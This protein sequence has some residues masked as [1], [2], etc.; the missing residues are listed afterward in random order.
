[1]GFNISS[2]LSNSG[3]ASAVLLQPV[4][5]HTTTHPHLAGCIPQSGTARRQRIWR[6]Q[7]SNY[8]SKSHRNP[9]NDNNYL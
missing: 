2:T 5:G 3:S 4:S 8:L 1:M 7:L 9:K 6:L